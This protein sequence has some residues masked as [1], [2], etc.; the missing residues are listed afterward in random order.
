MS[1]QV[2]GA[3]PRPA[4]DMEVVELLRAL[5]PEVLAHGDVV[6]IRIEL[7]ANEPPR[8]MVERYLTVAELGTVRKYVERWTV[9]CVDRTRAPAWPEGGFQADSNE[10]AVPARNAARDQATSS[11]HPL[12]Q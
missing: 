1:D 10:I 3:T 7:R 5:L 9:A 11:S 8:L 6:G 4:T 2:E 12:A